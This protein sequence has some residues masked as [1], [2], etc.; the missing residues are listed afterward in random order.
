MLN[1]GAEK[2][3]STRAT[4]DIDTRESTQPKSQR[5]GQDDDPV[6]WGG[7]IQSREAGGNT[8]IDNEQQE[9]S[10]LNSPQEEDDDPE[11]GA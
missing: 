1:D 8:G 5:E 7:D 9:G 2:D 11:R 10:G 6:R 4:S 3:S